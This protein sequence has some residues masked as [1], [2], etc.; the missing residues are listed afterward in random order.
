MSYRTNQTPIASLVDVLA[1]LEKS[2]KY[3]LQNPSTSEGLAPDEE[4]PQIEA[5]VASMTDVKFF[6]GESEKSAHT[7]RPYAVWTLGD[8]RQE[9]SQARGSGSK[10]PVSPR[11]FKK[12]LDL[13]QFTA[14][15]SSL[16]GA[17]DIDPTAP[18]DHWKRG[19]VKGCEI[20]RWAYWWALREHWGGQPRFEREGWIEVS[21]NNQLGYAWQSSFRV[22]MSQMRPNNL[23]MAT[24]PLD[25]TIENSPEER[26]FHSLRKS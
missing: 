11:P 25:V 3:F 12:S 13:I 9:G 22:P 2:I 19:T 20:L 21:G 5:P 24:Q 17:I 18:P 1:E 4:V 14:Y 15:G 10:N 26:F 23:T 7:S 16:D 6:L 8:T